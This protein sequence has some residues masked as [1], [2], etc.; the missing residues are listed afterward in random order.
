MLTTVLFSILPLFLIMLIG[1]LASR[2]AKFG[3]GAEP[4]ISAFVFY[5][6]LPALLFKVVAEAKIN[7]GIP[8]QF[9][10]IIVAACALFSALSILASR[11]L[12]RQDRPAAVQYALGS[13]FGNVAYLGVP[14]ILGI[15]GSDA[16]L[17][18]GIGQLTHNLFFML[19]YPILFPLLA[20]AKTEGSFG[21]K[22][23]TAADKAI[24]KNPVVW[25]IAAGLLVAAI[26]VP[27]P[28][29]IADTTNLLAAAAA[30]VALFAIGLTLRRTV[31]SLRSGHLSFAPVIGASLG[32]LIVFPVITVL[33]AGLLPGLPSDWYQVLVL[34]AAMP[35][36]ASGFI[37]AQAETDN[38]EATAANIVLSSILALVTIPVVAVVFLG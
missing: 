19:L 26:D 4:A 34:L 7:E 30:P 38:A 8:L 1:Y 33:I 31:T 5:I 2:S 35:T 20:A 9:P 21:A 32:K 17:A 22:I 16:G 36:S 18:A 14:V 23:R 37:L 10:L 6:A 29:P 24:L 13:S 12:F 11:F 25:G 27:L 3:A 15:V 28:G